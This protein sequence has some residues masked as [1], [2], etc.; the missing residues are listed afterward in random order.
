MNVFLVAIYVGLSLYKYSKTFYFFIPEME[1][2]YENMTKNT[3][4][5]HEAQLEKLS[6]YSQLK[7]EKSFEGKL[8]S[9]KEEYEKKLDDADKQKKSDIE[10]MTKIFNYKLAGLTAAYENYI[11]ALI[12]RHNES[13]QRMQKFLNANFQEMNKDYKDAKIEVVKVHHDENIRQ[14]G[15]KAS[16]TISDLETSTNVNLKEWKTVIKRRWLIKRRSMRKVKVNLV[17]S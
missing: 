4:I 16:E 17:I 6:S 12:D 1:D 5:D 9:I 10:N 14:N 3:S 8:S 15:H 13:I 11:E 2:I 7:L